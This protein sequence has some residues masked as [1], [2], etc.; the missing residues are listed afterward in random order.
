MDSFDGAPM[1]NVTFQLYTVD[2]IFNY[3]GERIVKADTLLGE[4]TTGEDGTLR[5][6]L[7]LPIAF[8]GSQNTGRYYFVEK[9]TPRGYAENA[10]KYEFVLS[11]VDQKTPEIVSRIDAKNDPIP[12]EFDIT[13]AVDKDTLQVRDCQDGKGDLTYT[14]TVTNDKGIFNEKLKMPRFDALFPC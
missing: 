10:A 13:K 3:K 2:D 9:E 12:P 7:G 4:V 1:A 8:E 11:Y 6:A 5:T 14:I